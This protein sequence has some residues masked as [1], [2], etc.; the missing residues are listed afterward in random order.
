MAVK[1]RQKIPNLNAWQLKTFSE[2]LLLIHSPLDLP[3]IPGAAVAALD[4][5]LPGDCYAYNEFHPDR[6]VTI[7]AP[8]QLDEKI[9]S[10][11]EF[12][13][14]EHPTV[15]HVA[16]TNMDKALRISDVSTLRE[17]RSTNLYNHVFRIADLNYQLGCIF[18][19]A[20]TSQAAFS[21]NRMARDFTAEQRDLMTLLSPHF[22]QAWVRANAVSQWNSVLASLAVAEVDRSGR[23]LFATEKAAAFIARYRTPASLSPQQLPEP[24]RGWLLQNIHEALVFEPFTPLLLEAGGRQL[25]VRLATSP[26]LGGYQLHFEE[27][28]IVTAA[29]VAERLGLT[30]RQGEVLFWIAEGKSNEEIALIL[31]AK[32]RTVAKH[33]EQIFVRIGVEN[34]SSATRLWH[35]CATSLRA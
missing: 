18:P 29:Q 33:V 25:T 3:S 19:I 11:F 35:E 15:K 30:P 31:D 23:I 32:V 2:A 8:D 22:A 24:Y 34:R 16:A 26:G 13:I 20:E 6:V 21:I 1:K 14:G 12:Y 27:K 7:A 9:S 4:K 5:L 10:A 28:P 17:W